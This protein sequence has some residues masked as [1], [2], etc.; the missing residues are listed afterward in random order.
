MRARQW[1][2]AFRYGCPA[3]YGVPVLPAWEQRHD[4]A[5]RLTLSDR[6]ADEPFLSAENP[7]TVRR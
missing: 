4:D 7:M 2:I 3:D 5:G 1:L 6:G